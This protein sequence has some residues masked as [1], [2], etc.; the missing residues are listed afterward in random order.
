MAHRNINLSDYFDRFIDSQVAAGNFRT[1]DEVITEALRLLEIR[2]PR[3]V[4]K[5]IPE[6]ADLDIELG[7]L[8]DISALMSQM[9]REAQAAES[10]EED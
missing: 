2:Q 4:R 1:A 6:E 5:L 7:S 10:E 9:Q 3:E 8:S